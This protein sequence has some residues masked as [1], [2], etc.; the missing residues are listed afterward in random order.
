LILIGEKINGTRKSVQKAILE[1]DASAICMLV[2]EQAEAGADY[3]DVNA[4]TGP[5]REQEDMLW[6]LELVQK[7][8]PDVSICIDSSSSETLRAALEHVEKTPMVNSINADARRLENFIPLISQRKCPV[9]ALALDESK[10]GMPK[11][12]A[13]RMDNLKR[14]FNATRNAGIPDENVFVDPL[15]MAVATDNKAA[16]EVLECIRNIHAEYPNAHITGGLSNISFGLPE[17][18]L[19]NHTFLTLAMREGMDSAVCNPAN[20]SLI[21]A[22]KTTEMLLGKD[23]FCRNYTKAAK[24]GFVRK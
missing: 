12:N 11:S 4:G 5:E 2:K 23:R 13:E 9:I 17:R 1:R 22:V 19:V 18:S 6:L 20:H 16:L 21:G 10:S 24:N 15:I 3:L 7:E 14:I 8:A